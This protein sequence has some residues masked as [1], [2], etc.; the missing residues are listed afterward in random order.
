MGTQEP[1]WMKPNT[2]FFYGNLTEYMSL[3]WG[4]ASTMVS[5]LIWF[6]VVLGFRDPKVL[7]AYNVFTGL[8]AAGTIGGCVY[9]ALLFPVFPWDN[10]LKIPFFTLRALVN[11]VFFYM[12]ASFAGLFLVATLIGLYKIAQAAKAGSAT[13]VA[14]LKRMLP[15]IF[16]QLFGFGW[17]CWGL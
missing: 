6:K 8:M 1:I 13:L 17:L 14:V 9:V 7:K 2:T 5:A 3:P 15:W 10:W 4:N 16:L 12:Q 11:D